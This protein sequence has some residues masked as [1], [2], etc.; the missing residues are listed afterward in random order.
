MKEHGIAFL[1]L[2]ALALSMVMS[3]CGEN[4]ASGE[5]TK[6]AEQQE[7]ILITDVS[8]PITMLEEFPGAEVTTNRALRPTKPK[9]VPKIVPISQKVPD[10]DGYISIAWGDLE[11]PDL[12][13]NEALIE[14]KKQ[15]ALIPEG[16]VREKELLARYQEI[17][18]NAPVN[19]ELNGKKIK[20]Q[21]FVTALEVNKGLINDFLLVPYYGACIHVPPPPINQTLYIKPDAEQ[22]LM[23]KDTYLPVT[24]IGTIK[25]DKAA[26]ELAEAGYQIID[27]KVEI[28]DRRKMAAPL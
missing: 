16:D 3:G 18:N 10:K 7:Q 24:V 1:S 6:N 5:T 23:M 26:T 9:A 20:L 19:D 8:T 22:K 27:A 15:V 4:S 11:T 21:G 2:S 28:T 12:G 13:K 17:I 14:F 25:V